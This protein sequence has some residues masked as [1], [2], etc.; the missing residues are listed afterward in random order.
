MTVVAEHNALE[1]I[2]AKAP[3]M[4]EEG[5]PNEKPDR[6]NEARQGK[7]AP[8]PFFCQEEF[9]MR[10]Y[11][12]KAQYY[13]TDRMGIIH[14]SNYIRWF[15]EARV[16]FLEQIGMPFETVEARGLSSPVLS[17]SVSTKA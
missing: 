15:E 1:V 11:E 4:I 16:D 3:E 2:R 5:F 9:F 12:H 13:E 14:H 8:S 6:V 17:V 10:P 7:A